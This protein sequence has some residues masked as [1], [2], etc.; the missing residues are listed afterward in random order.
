MLKEQMEVSILDV[1]HKIELLRTELFEIQV[2]K[3]KLIEQKLIEISNKYDDIT[4]K[5]QDQVNDLILR[6]KR[7][8]SDH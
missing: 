2:N 4:N 1:N 7:E 3:E 6:R 8:L 5:V